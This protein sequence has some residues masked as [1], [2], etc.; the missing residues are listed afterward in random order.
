MSPDRNAQM[1]DPVEDAYRVDPEAFK[2]AGRSDGNGADDDAAPGISAVI[3]DVTKHLR[4]AADYG[5]YFLSAKVDGVKT[6]LR[7]VALYAALGLVGA[8]VGVSVL[9]TAA[10]M[11][12]SG[13]A[14]ILGTM[15]GG[16][17]NL[18]SFLVGLLVLA[19]VVVGAL[20]FFKKF[21]A[22][23]RQ[24]TVEKYESRKHQQ[25]AQYGHD[26]DERSAAAT[27]AAQAA[28]KPVARA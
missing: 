15:F 19:G 10:V 20:V 9:V 22:A 4:E 12:L 25:R 7:N 1:Y 17:Y 24:R 5:T 6:S 18:S 23:S 16:R 13:L 27:A 11:L 14:G 3:G 8:I 28:G 21:T 2:T 26:V